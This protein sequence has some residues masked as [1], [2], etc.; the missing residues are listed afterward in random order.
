MLTVAVVVPVYAGERYLRE[1]VSE[2]NAVRTGW[3]SDGGP[4]S[5]ASLVLVTDEPI[6]GSASL[7]DELAA[8]H[9]WVHVVHLSRN[10]GQHPATIAGILRTVEDWVV[11][12][13]EDLQHPPARITDLLAHA[14]GTSRDLV[15]ARP[16]SAVHQTR[17]R[18][19]SSRLAKRLIG[20]AGG[21]RLILEANSFRLVRGS[22]ARAAAGASRYDTYLDVALFWFTRRVATVTMT[23]KDRRFIES[24]QSGYRLRSLVSHARRLLISNQIKIL[25]LGAA[26]GGFMAAAS[27][28]LGLLVLAAR[29]L[30]PDLVTAPGWASLMITLALFGGALMLMI[31]VMQEFL[32]LLLVRSNG[33]PVFF[34]VDRSTD[35]EVAAWF[36]TR[37]TIREHPPFHGD[38]TEKRHG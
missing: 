3:Q 32:S 9:Q 11:T 26:V 21:D 36:A 2:V 12:L 33:R 7:A 4:A 18:D 5:L 14:V 6:D 28:A 22:V 38:E 13:D 19:V 16:Q 34:A 25:R 29:L 27:G 31:G 8:E 1:L 23:M 35:R 15:Y 17:S 24:C 37:A 20:W 10:Y 30:A